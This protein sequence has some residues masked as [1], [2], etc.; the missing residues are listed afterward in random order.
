MRIDD[1]QAFYFPLFGAPF[2]ANMFLYFCSLHSQYIV[3]V[4]AAT[5]TIVVIIGRQHSR[6]QPIA[7]IVQ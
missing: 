6:K 4:V 1:S 2:L 5:T 7:A 3:V